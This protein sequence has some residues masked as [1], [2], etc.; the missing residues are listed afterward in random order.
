MKI[1]YDKSSDAVH[2]EFDETLEEKLEYDHI[3]GEWPININISTTG[4]AMGIEIL[5][6]STI[7][8]A[9]L[10]ENPENFKP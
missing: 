10:L 1:K 7:L 3:D 6:A 2:I 4:K 5:N 8:S 9:S